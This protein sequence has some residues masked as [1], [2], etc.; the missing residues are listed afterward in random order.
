MKPSPLDYTRAS[1]LDHVVELLANA[2]DETR[3]IAGGQ[4]LGPL[5]NL[6]L[7]SPRRL[8]D[9]SHIDEL[10]RARIEG[11]DLAIG[12][13]VTHA[14]VEDGELP[15]VTHGLMQHVARGIAYRAVRNRGT[16]GG[17][18]AHA[19]PAADWIATM[20]ALGARV[21]LRGC[22]DERVLE[23]EELI[24]GPLSTVIA[25]DEVITS[26]RVPRLSSGARWGHSKF[27]RKLGDFAD[28]MAIVVVD[29]D[30]SFVS[31]VLA[32]R[33]E[34]P[35]RLPRMIAALTAPDLQ[36]AIDDAIDSDL[37]SLRIEAEDVRLHRAMIRRAT[38]EA[39][40]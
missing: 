28:S 5:L 25:P 3:I 24:N 19:D 6:R 12:P 13:C 17:S 36:G 16:I 10:R 37:K 14:Q 2:T 33:A 39:T 11:T 18:L 9:I 35:A 23:I 15:D 22:R 40:R 38:R 8:I 30:R 21:Q 7:A 1:S 4:S 26:I 31:G 29:R 34:P 27:A 32:R 20:A